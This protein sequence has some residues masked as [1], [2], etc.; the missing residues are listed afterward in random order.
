MK[1]KRSNTKEKRVLYLGGVVVI[2]VFLVGWIASAGGV[3]M[4]LGSFFGKSPEVDFVGPV[5]SSGV[6]VGAI[7]FDAWFSPD[8]YGHENRLEPV[9][10]HDRLPFY[11][12]INTD[13]SV[14]VRGDSQTTVDQEI[15]YA[16]DGGLDYWA[17]DY[18]GIYGKK[19]RRGDSAWGGLH[20]G[21][22]YYLSSEYRE[23]LNFALNV[24]GEWLFE[25]DDTSKWDREFVPTVISLMK[26]DGYQTVLN[27]RP[28]IYIYKMDK[29]SEKMGGDEE[30]AKG[31]ARLRKAAVRN[32]LKDP[33]I[34]GLLWGY[35]HPSESVMQYG[36]DAVSA[37][38]AHRGNDYNDGR[39]WPYSD[40]ALSNSRLWERLSNE[41]VEVVPIVNV[42][43]DYRPNIANNNN[44]K[45]I[46]SYE[47]SPLYERAKPWEIRNHLMDAV[48]WVKTHSKNAKSKAILI[49][50][51]S[52]YPEGGM[53]AP[54]LNEGSVR[55]NAIALGLGRNQEV[56]SMLKLKV[57]KK[58]ENLAVSWDGSVANNPEFDLFWLAVNR[59]D[60]GDRV[61]AKNVKKSQSHTV[62]MMS[63]GEYMLRLQAINK[64][65]TRI[66]EQVE[67][68]ITGGVLTIK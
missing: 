30:L 41:D 32:G 52:E 3:G 11:A 56:E 39:L 48:S 5:D 4:W 20:Y 59:K 37:Y 46:E 12:K 35:T 33:Y 50:S 27:K 51:W 60:N 19:P 13:G 28:L 47:N 22:R 24:T 1:K 7:R 18:Y 10:Y 16:A 2:L 25:G 65:K 38:T 42:G 67:I 66:A 26:E 23:Q 54:S 40:L 68:E 34:V 9:E 43:W 8:N 29:A 53:L 49:Y 62:P 17:F 64:D 14:E 58:N 6:V 45:A 61:Y 15:Q 55:L 57:V 36:V 31:I 44:E 21:L 63:D